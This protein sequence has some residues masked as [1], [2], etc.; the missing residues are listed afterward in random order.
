MQYGISTHIFL[1]QRLTPVL[2]DS[3][4]QT[5]AGQIEVFAS[6]HHFDYADR[7]AVREIANWFRANPVVASLHMPLFTEDEEAN[8]SKHTAATLNLLH[9]SKNERIAAQDEVKRALEAA[10]QVPFKSCVLHLGNKEQEWNTRALDDAL[11]AVEHLKAFAGPLGVQLLLENLNND[12]AKPERLAEIVKVGHFSTVGF[13]LDIGHA[14]L[15][16]GIAETSHAPAQSGLDL[17]FAA[18]GDKLVELHAH[19]NHG[20]DNHGSAKDEHCWPGEG[21]IDF[22]VVREHLRGL[23]QPLAGLLEI[24]YEPATKPGEM[25]G[26]CERGWELLAV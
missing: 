8:W 19:D 4:L 6:R 16:D 9:D 22:G 25:K 21:T 26:K 14:A 7:G 24:A 11:S 3:L 2:L 1:P 10:E 20:A 18:M 5:G 13:C 17:A 15:E 23:K 12:I